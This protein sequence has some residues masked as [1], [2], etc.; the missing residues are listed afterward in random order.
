[1]AHPCYAH[2]L[3]TRREPHRPR[4]CRFTSRPRPAP[5]L[6]L[7]PP[8]SHP[9]RAPRPRPA[10]ARTDAD[11]S[12][13]ARPARALAVPRC[14][15]RSTSSSPW[16]SRCHAPAP[17]LAATEPWPSN[18]GLDMIYPRRAR[19]WPTLCRCSRIAHCQSVRVLSPGRMSAAPSAYFHSF[20]RLSPLRAS[21]AVSSSSVPLR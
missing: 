5:M 20:C 18:L 19:P 8:G 11:T 13:T 6:D 17:L 9:C 4:P 7:C 21:L 12:S 1:M 3:G 2:Q 14:G 16:L 15:R 10:V